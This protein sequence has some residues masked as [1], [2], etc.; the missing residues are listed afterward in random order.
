MKLSKFICLVGFITLTCII[1]VGLQ[2]QIFELAYTGK[3]KEKAFKELLD[4][5]NTM[6]Y[7]V[8]LLE[9]AQNLGT[10]LLSKDA[11]LQ[12][13]DKSQLAKIDMPV[14]LASTFNQAPKSENKKANFLVNFF[15]LKSEAQARPIK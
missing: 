5:K 15:S 9:S 12:F 8:F 14:Q 10:A 4:R 7:N 6:M 13:T 11:N 3:R 2:V 1:Y